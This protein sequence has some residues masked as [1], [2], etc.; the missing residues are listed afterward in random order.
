MVLS[1]R[2]GFL[3]NLVYNFSKHYLKINNGFLEFEIVHKKIIC[4]LCEI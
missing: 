3:V 4:R 1:E 2:I